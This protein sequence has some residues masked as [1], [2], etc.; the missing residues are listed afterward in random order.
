MGSDVFRDNASPSVQQTTVV[1]GRVKPCQFAELRMWKHWGM[2]GLRPLLVSPSLSCKQ[3]QMSSYLLQS[4]YHHRF[5]SEHVSN[6]NKWQKP[7]GW[8]EFGSNPI[9]QPTISAN[10]RGC[11]AV[12]QPAQD[13]SHGQCLD[14][15]PP[16]QSRS[17][18]TGLMFH[19]PRAGGLF[20]S[21]KNGPWNDGNF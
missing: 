16:C 1:P 17:N 10:T 20:F 19:C 6:L 4:F 18:L 2:Q 9:I 8:I 3:F 11:L 12:F 15:C 21:S 7:P 5:S 14:V 13:Q